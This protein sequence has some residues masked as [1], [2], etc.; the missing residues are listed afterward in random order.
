MFSLAATGL[1]MDRPGHARLAGGGGCAAGDPSAEPAAIPRDI[2]G[3]DGIP[4]GGHAAAAA[5]HPLRAMAAAGGSHP[6]GRA[7][8]AGRGRAV[9]GIGRPG[10]RTRRPGASRVG[11]RRL[12]FDGLQ[13]GR[14][15]AVRPGERDR[16]ADRR[17][18]RRRGRLHAGLDVLVTAGGGGHG[19]LEHGRNPPGNRQPPASPRR[20]RSAGRRGRGR[21][22]CRERRPRESPPHS[23]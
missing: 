15:V 16:P 17:G 14:A 2:L 5:P 1:R 8:G 9:P 12:L 11:V 13:A 22:A 6:A 4:A 19:R 23:P 21:A 18:E 10:L 3:G 7:G 20:G